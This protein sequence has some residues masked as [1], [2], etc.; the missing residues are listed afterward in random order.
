[1]PHGCPVPPRGWSDPPAPRGVCLQ[2]LF[3]SCFPGQE[4]FSVLGT[5]LAAGLGLLILL[6]LGYTFVRWCQRG[7]CCRGER[8]QGWGSGSSGQVVPRDKGCRT[9]DVGSTP[10]VCWPLWDPHAG[11]LW[12]ELEVSRGQGG[13]CRLMSCCLPCPPPQP[14]PDSWQSK[15]ELVA[16]HT[17]DLSPSHL[18]RP[19]LCLQ[20]L[21]QTVSGGLGWAGCSLC[22]VPKCCQPSPV[23]ELPGAGAGQ[24]A[25]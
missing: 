11:R 21:P 12:D 13:G 8:G 7:Q 24:A 5:A 4:S 14:C 10:G 18:P 2:S 20:P 6:L 17:P 9:W 25:H 23:P 1:M 16:P 22:M 3:S 19:R 15:G